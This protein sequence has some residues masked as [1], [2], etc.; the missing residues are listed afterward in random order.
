MNRFIFSICAVGLFFAAGQ[1]LQCYK[2]DIGFW[3]LCITTKT[4]CTGTDQCYSGVGK[5]AKV[6]D[7]KMKGCLNVSECNRVTDV[8]FTGNSILYQMNKTCCNTDL[9][10]AAP[11]QAR[12][13]LLSLTLAT[14]AGA[15]VANAVV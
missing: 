12:V 13:T 5:A 10:N 3:N 6:I 11:H 7:I 8:T 14:L 1:A 9:C 15:I 4:D 2:C